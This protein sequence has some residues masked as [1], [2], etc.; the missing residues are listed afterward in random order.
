[1]RVSLRLDASTQGTA[2]RNHL[3]RSLYAEF[4]RVLRA[5]YLRSLLTI[6]RGFPGTRSF[7]AFSERT[8]FTA[9]PH[10]WNAEPSGAVADA[11]ALIGSIDRVEAAGRDRFAS[12]RPVCHN[13]PVFSSRTAAALAPPNRLARLLEAKR[14]AGAR[15]LDLTESNPTRCGFDYPAG[16]ILGAL[17]HPRGLRYEPQPR[18]APEARAAV[19][20]Y[21]AG[22]GAAV[23]PA[24][25][26]LT[27]STSEAYS[28]LFTLLADPG[29]A[30]LAPVP[31][32]PL[33]EHLTALASVRLAPYP[34]GFDGDTWWIDL[35]AL[36]A[37]LDREPRAR[38]VVVVS[39]NNPTGSF[40]ARDELAAL[41]AR[42]AER[43]LALIAD[44]V[45]ADYAYGDDPGRAGTLA[46]G[47]AWAAAAAGKR[48]GEGVSSPP[49]GSAWSPDNEEG[50][51][52]PGTGLFG[53]APRTTQSPGVAAAGVPRPPGDASRPGWHCRVPASP[54]EK[55]EGE[56][57]D[58]SAPG[59]SE[60]LAFALSGLS[61]VAG[62]PQ[63]KLGWIVV[64][65][66]PPLLSAALDRLDLVA[67][68][69]LSVGTPVQAALP[70]LLALA[71]AVQAQIRARVAGNRACLEAAVAAGSPCRVLPAEGGWYAVVQ[72]PRLRS[73]EA[74]VLELL[75]A[76]DVLVHPG[77]F[78]DFP[79]EAYLVVSLLPEPRT[80]EPAVER[81]LRRAASAP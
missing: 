55:Q 65:G 40:L 61:K 75:D 78:F 26:V 60:P 3:R 79:A 34:L 1:M 44:E 63:L 53:R 20:S 72:V 12:R 64:S 67:D 66:P 6:H 32:Y 28:F 31:S 52:T 68:T 13:L 23:D 24:H 62:L 22:R 8:V 70:E 35:P 14:R 9:L 74:L 27:A 71:P 21:Y 76:D 54:H 29:D 18:G 51:G 57:S 73:E 7:F 48:A 80:F 58:P 46:G 69:F 42:C 25:V 39:P 10:P 45:F 19:A 30:I 56:A 16:A 81:L 38:A 77:Y 36:A 50:A 49:G 4:P 11:V 5:A 59:F 15:L 37:A 41:A 17:A 47:V 33:L 2:A 43:G